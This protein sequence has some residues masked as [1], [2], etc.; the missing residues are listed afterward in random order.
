MSGICCPFGGPQYADCCGK[1]S[2]YDDCNNACGGDNTDACGWVAG[3]NAKCPF[4]ESFYQP[5]GVCCTPSGH[6]TN[7]MYTAKDANHCRRLGGTWF[8]NR[9]TCDMP[10][11][12]TNTS[13]ENFS[14]APSNTI[15]TSCIL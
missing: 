15:Y 1:A 12:Y 9:N 10:T 7:A 8:H 4:N 11:S 3:S 2:N 14:V 5:Q 13:V 6:V